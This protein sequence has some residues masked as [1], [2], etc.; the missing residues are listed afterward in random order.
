M[1]QPL[2]SSQLSKQSNKA[3]LK[4]IIGLFGITIVLFSIHWLLTPSAKL[5]SLRTAKIEIAD[6]ASTISA[7]GII[8]PANESTL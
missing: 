1:D 5:S 3:K 2:S 6:I 8:I 4:V 7:G